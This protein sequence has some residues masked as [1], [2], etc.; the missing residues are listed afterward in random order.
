MEF[1]NQPGC[2]SGLMC[3]ALGPIKNYII[4]KRMKIIGKGAFEA[5]PDL[6]QK[7]KKAPR[8]CG[9]K[10]KFLLAY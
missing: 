3:W 7:Q 5:P 8:D 9:Q 6:C 1:R 10:R 4:R 2:K